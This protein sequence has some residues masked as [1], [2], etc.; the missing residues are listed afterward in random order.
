[1]V[2]KSRR[3]SH[4]ADSME[5]NSIWFFVFIE[6]YDGALKILQ[7]RRNDYNA[8]LHSNDNQIELFWSDNDDPSDGNKNGDMTGQ[9]DTVVNS[10]EH[11]D[12]PDANRTIENSRIQVEL[13]TTAMWQA[14]VMH[15]LTLIMS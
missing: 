5:N 9:S 10:A 2:R 8:G 15:V 7:R 11:R 12:S 3:K 14:K 4:Y 1:M 6:T 13:V